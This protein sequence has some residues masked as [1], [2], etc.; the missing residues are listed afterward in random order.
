MAG[1]DDGEPTPASAAEKQRK[2]SMKQ[3]SVTEMIRQMDGAAAS[4]K[5]DRS[6]SGE[7]ASPI[8]RGGKAR[9][10]DDWAKFE[11]VLEGALEKLRHQ[12]QDDLNQFMN[13]VKEQLGA[14]GG[15]LREVE[16]K[17][18]RKEKQLAEMADTV[19]ETTRELHALREQVEENE[20]ISRL[21]SLVLSGSAIGG[22]PAEPGP[23]GENVEQLVVDTLKKHF[24]DLP[25][26]LEDIDRA[27]R[28]PGESGR[29]IICRFTKSGRGSI[30]DT[31]YQRRME[32]RG[33][34]LYINECL[35]RR[36]SE[37]FQ[38]LLRAKKE[39][40]IYT[41]FSRYGQVY[42]KGTKLGK[43][44]RVSSV[45]DTLRQFEAS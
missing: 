40:K 12:I 28:L 21:P 30:R 1:N 25:I 44:V 23:D 18:E 8:Q 41:V 5:R 22:R 36:R 39:N 16:V 10:T 31:I 15:R 6:E 35:T 27:H 37:L 43:S 32:L 7:S 33:R 11:A 17:L 19:Q 13:S 20:L 9:D 38:I 14:L 3:C 45:I 42:Y 2:Q 4:N 29:K 34:E 26:R 24:R